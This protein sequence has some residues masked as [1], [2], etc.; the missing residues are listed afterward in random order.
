MGN[1]M[2]NLALHKEAD[3]KNNQFDEEDDVNIDDVV[4]TITT[5]SQPGTP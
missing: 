1:Y 5:T 4:S 2:A 3:A